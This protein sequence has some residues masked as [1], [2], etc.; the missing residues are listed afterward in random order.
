[1]EYSLKITKEISTD[2]LVIGAGTAGVFA[3]ITAARE[4]ASVMLVEKGSMCG[5]TI[6]S[7]GVDYPGIFHAWGKQIIDGPCFESVKRAEILGGAVI[8]EIVY[9]PDRHWKMQVR[10]NVFTY[11]HV[12]EEMLSES[13]VNVLYHTL[14]ADIKETENGV[15][16]LLV[17][18]EGCILVNA[19]A[20]IDASGDA[21]AVSKA[22]FGVLKSETLQPATLIND[23]SGYEFSEALAPAVNSV[24]DKAMESGEISKRDL[25]GRKPM[26]ILREKRIHCHIH[27]SLPESSEGKTKLEM[28]ARNCVFKV[29]SVFKRVKGLENI[30]VHSFFSECGVRESLRIDAH[31][32]ITSEDYVSGKV[33]EDAV[34]YAF[35][36]VDLH[37]DHAI[38]QTFLEEG[39][40]PTIPYSA[41]VPKGSKYILACG[42]IIGSDTDA[43]SA[44]RVQAPCMATGQV[45]GAAAAIMAKDGGDVHV[46]YGKL[47]ENL[48]KIGA[49]VPEKN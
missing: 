7:C 3:A 10:L 42:R 22:G 20:A 26:D 28:E 30:K 11:V 41:L 12:L 14:L 27:T 48:R 2:V 9:K 39:V 24:F 45:C 36:P 40:V 33:Y 23:I 25:Q 43:N 1:M 4:G 37:T 15:Q 34:C 29:L 46:D 17:T 49:I 47:C 8:P 21:N 13:G 44:L 16:A 32:N 31:T 19:K 5:G 38:M 35:Y 18:K 6:T